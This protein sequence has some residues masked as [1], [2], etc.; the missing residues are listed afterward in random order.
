M[1]ISHVFINEALCS[2]YRPLCQNYSQNPF[3]IISSVK[4]LGAVS[5]FCKYNLFDIVPWIALQVSVPIFTINKMPDV[6]L[7]Y[8]Q[9][10]QTLVVKT[11]S[12]SSFL[13]SPEEEEGGWG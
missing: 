7:F 4:Y 9:I 8:H 13:I 1:V 10:V 3:T 2:T 5:D 11:G 12:I 6:L